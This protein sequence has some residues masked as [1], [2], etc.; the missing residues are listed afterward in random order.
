MKV[1]RLFLVATALLLTLSV[2][3]FA[4]T[5]YEFEQADAGLT[6]LYYFSDSDDDGLI[7]SDEISVGTNPNLSDTDGDGE[8]DYDE[9]GSPASPYDQDTDGKIDALESSLLDEDGDGINDEEDP[10]D[11]DTCEPDFYSINCDSDYDGLPNGVEENIGTNYISND[12]D[13][14]GENDSDEVGNNYELPDDADNDG[15]IDALE[16]ELEDNDG[17]NVNAEEDPNESDPC[18]PD[19]SAGSCDQ[20]N[21]GLTNFEEELVGSDPENPNSDGDGELDGEEVTDP[22]NPDDTDNDGIY[23]VFES[24]EIDDDGDSYDN[25]GDP[26]DSNPCI[27]DSS[28]AGCV[29]GS[30]RLDS[31]DDGLTDEQENSLGTDPNNEDTDGDGTNDYDEVGDPEF[32]EDGDFDGIINALESEQEDSDGDGYNDQEDGDDN[33]NCTPDSEVGDCDQDGDGLTNDEELQ[34]G[35]DPTIDDTDDD[36]V[37]DGEEVGPDPENPIDSNNDSIPDAVQQEVVAE[38]E[39]QAGNPVSENNQ[40]DSEMSEGNN[41]TTTVFGNDNIQL[42]ILN[43]CEFNNQP[44]FSDNLVSE[45]ANIIGLISFRI[46]NCS[47]TSITI[48]WSGLDPNLD[49][50]VIK[51]GP[52]V[53][54]N[55]SSIELYA[56]PASVTK[57][58]DQII[59]TYQLVD[60]EQGDD[61]IVD[62]EIVDPVGL[63]IV[64]LAENST[65]Q[66]SISL[67]QTGG[68]SIDWF[69][70]I[71]GLSQLLWLRQEQINSV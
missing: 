50:E 70:V 58:A 55:L 64:E 31:D 23:D 3:Y 47:S 54:G 51:Y 67:V 71:V 62:G 2:G 65:Q 4:S 6:P 37:T 48:T 43:E 41:Q 24:S 26:D 7:D 10:N 22:Y 15:I 9:V 35:T 21:D 49:Y 68:S 16:S 42:E 12:T 18:I 32:P 28:A 14:D 40:E 56:Y 1:Y 13:M 38:Q 59:A 57:T 63:R 25:E 34:I 8:S 44:V 36:G 45:D 27:P 60:G 20:D 69:I 33:D 30:G 19:Q 52:R 17:D 66:Q 29:F 53:P 61:T 39:E 46:S 5:Q 11:Q